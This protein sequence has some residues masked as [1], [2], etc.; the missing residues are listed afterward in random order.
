M[1]ILCWAITEATDIATVGLCHSVPHTAEAIADYI[2]APV[3]EL[4]YWVAGINHLAWFLECEY[5]GEDVTPMLEE[6]MQDEETYRRD[7]VRFE[8][9]EHFGAFPTESSHH[10]SEYL[11]YFRTEP[12][13]IERFDG[14]DF[15]GRMPTATYLE[16]WLEKAAEYEDTGEAGATDEA[17][18]QG[19]KVDEDDV[20]IERSEEYASRIIH[21]L[22]TDT[23]RRFNLNVPNH[24]GSITNLPEDA[25][26]EVPT[27]VD[28]AGVHT[29]DVGDL[30]PQLAALDRSNI[31]V[32]ERAVTG[33]LNNDRRA[34][35]QAIKLDPLSSAVLTLDEIHEMTE[36][37]IEANAD[38]LPELD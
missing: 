12:E 22:E 7:T 13:T 25:C 32:Q 9:F 5:K 17:A 29:C 21:S 14:T 3:E 27:F 20:E 2:G 34:I 37:L 11:P 4:D 28:G 23:A 30:P 24:D 38:V 8:L 31:A 26:V 35:H 18:Q 33:A 1:A 6:A 19:T 10:I 16:G 15:A 36:E